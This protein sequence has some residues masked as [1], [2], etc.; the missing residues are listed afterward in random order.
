MTKSST[1]LT[2]ASV[3]AAGLLAYAIYFDYKRRNDVEFRKK[4]RK[5]KKRAEKSAAESRESLAASA[6]GNELSPEQL[7][8]ALELVK[9]EP[10][11]PGAA[12]KENYF[13][14]QVA[15]G[16]QLA[17]RGPEFHLPAA[18]AFYRALRVYPSPLELIA[19]YDKTVPP[20]I[21]KIVM[22]L[23]N[24]DV[25][26]ILVDGAIVEGGEQEAESTS[27]RHSAETSPSRAPSEASSQ[28][29][30]KITDPGSQTPSTH[31]EDL[32]LAYFDYFPPKSMG[33]AIVTQDSTSLQGSRKV[34]VASKDYQPGDLIYKEQPV[35]TVLDNDL[36][37]QGSYCTHCLRHIEKGMAIP[38]SPS[39]PFPSVWCSKDCQLKSRTQYHSLLFT[40]D[41]PLPPDV[42]TPPVS[43]QE[44]EERR[45]AQSLFAEYLLK[46]GNAAPLLAAKFI[47]RQVQNETSK[48][49]ASAPPAEIDYP[50]AEGGDYGLTDHLERLR[51][52]E[53]VPSAEEM[54]LLTDVLQ[55]ALPGLEQFVTDERHAI[56]L[57]K[58]AYN[59]FGVCYG[60][61]R[62]DKPETDKRPED[63]E[64]TRTPYGTAKQIGCGLYIVSA[65]LM[66]SCAPN[67]RPSFSNG[68][69]ELHLIANKPIKKGDEISVAYVDIT[70]HEGES[71]VD[72]RARRRKELAR[73]WRFACKCSKC[74]AE[75]EAA[76]TSTEGDVPETQKDESKVDSA[77]TRFEEEEGRA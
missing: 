39:E 19:I 53:T 27:S 73:G 4:L 33:V 22:E 67:A 70:Q 63:V 7:R 12:E 65:Y 57:G 17:T 58:M 48:L 13:M 14:S 47:A 23:T 55:H 25:S 49:M 20:A 2:V 75:S 74:V 71:A 45:K 9:N 26:T 18:L 43:P 21:F 54:R 46:N 15:M 1:V 30:D 36:R 59:A 60:G 32:I 62:D 38:S 29:W 42:P 76:E 31:A 56:L 77:L 41:P 50:T 44:L 64:K 51:F 40:L 69:A 72:A 16:E 10:P 28:E 37:S 3:T 5:D 61:G 68:T 34:L 66:H 8:E 11:P 35:A 52:L 6:S 24:L